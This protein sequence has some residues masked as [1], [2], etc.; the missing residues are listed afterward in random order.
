MG[1]QLKH[2]VVQFK[3]G[4]EL[5]KKMRLRAKRVVDQ[6]ELP[7]SEQ[8]PISS[9]QGMHAAKSLVRSMTLCS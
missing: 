3:I 2:L 7:Q 5:N 1:I 6:S 4:R 9:N 8:Q